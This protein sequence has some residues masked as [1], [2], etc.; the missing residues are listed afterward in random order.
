[1]LDIALEKPH[2]LAAFRDAARGLIAAGI[3]FRDVIWHEGGEEGLFSTPFLPS[4]EPLAVPASFVALAENVILH[5]DRERLP[6]LYEL[7][8][9]I[10]HG[11]RELI[12][13][14]ADPLVHRLGMM[15]K[16]IGRDIHKM[17]A[18]VRFRHVEDQ[19]G[20]RYIAWFEPEHFILDKVAPFFTGRFPA[21]RWSILTPIGSLHWDGEELQRG[22]AV[23]RAEAPR[24]DALEEWW[25]TYY[26]A[27]FDPARANPGIMQ[28][29]MP[30][31]YWR[32]LPEATI[33]PDLLSEAHGRTAGMLEA[34]PTV[35]RKRISTAGNLALALDEGMPDVGAN[36]TIAAL[37]KDAADCT[38]CHLYKHAT[39]TVFGE[40]P[41]D[42]RIVMVGEQPGDQEDL[43]GRPFVGPAG[44]LL[45][46]ALEEAG[47][48]R[49]EVYVTNAVKHF[50][51]EPR[52]KKRIHKKPDRPE[53]EACKWWLERELAVLSPELIVALGG[54]AGQALFGRPVKVLSERGKIGEDARG[55]LTLIT[56]HPS[57]ILRIPDEASKREAFRDFVRDLKKAA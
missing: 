15:R 3:G 5:R 39:Q 28:A 26:R 51:F 41:E 7:I 45:D 18:F 10:L 1:M 11:E 14:A 57:M 20:E 23:S 46:R 56:I 22:E 27:A 37:R 12:R 9:R 33:I 16:A 13:I 43:Q 25:R 40:G 34:P 8:W 19:D 32:N 21:M 48:A 44:K 50:K 42:A 29:E 17:H 24:E 4:G 36:T 2:D 38:R 54:T 49:D 55:F 35:P 31:R 52:G 53:I 6:L 30:K 47:I